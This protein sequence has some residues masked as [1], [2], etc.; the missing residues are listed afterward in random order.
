M[1]MDSS[2]IELIQVKLNQARSEYRALQKWLKENR[3]KIPGN[4]TVMLAVYKEPTETLP[5]R[6]TIRHV[7]EESQSKS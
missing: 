7:K 1:M 5:G 4:V 6:W 2:G 3:D